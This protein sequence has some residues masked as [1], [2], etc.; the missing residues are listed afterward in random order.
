[1]DMVSF[2][3]MVPAAIGVAGLLTYFTRKRKPASDLELVNL[4]QSVRTAFVLLGCAALIMLT[5]WLIYRPMPPEHDVALSAG[6]HLSGM[7]ARHRPDFGKRAG[8]FVNWRLVA[9]FA[10]RDNVQGLVRQQVL[11]GGCFAG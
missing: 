3:K 7:S 5:V 4:V 8:L 6:M 10:P 1:M 11:Q 9:L 2:L